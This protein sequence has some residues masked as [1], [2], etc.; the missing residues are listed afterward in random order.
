VQ[1]SSNIVKNSVNFLRQQR[2]QVTGRLR[3]VLAVVAA[4]TFA[5]S[6]AAQLF[7]PAPVRAA[8]R[9]APRPSPK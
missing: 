6:P 4:I 7:T 9:P 1:F 2:I 3:Q 8:G 5:L